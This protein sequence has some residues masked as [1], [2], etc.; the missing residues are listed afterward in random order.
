MW[1]A[2]SDYIFAL[3]YFLKFVRFAN[4][5]RETPFPE[6]VRWLEAAQKIN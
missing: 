6:E 5:D 4:T 2:G 1:L 3:E